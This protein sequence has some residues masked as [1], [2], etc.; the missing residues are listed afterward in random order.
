MCKNRILFYSHDA[1]G[2]GN[3]RR[4]L[5]M[6][7]RLTQTIPNLSILILTGSPVI[8]ALRIPEKV[9]YIK[10][11]CITRNKRE[12]FV[13]KYWDM[14]LKEMMNFRS[15][16]ILSSI[17]SFQ[18][19]IMIVDK[20]PLGI[21]R[22]LFDAL[23]FL[24]NFLP[25]TRI[26]LG[27]RDIL[28]EPATTIPIWQNNGYFDIIRDYYDAIWIY[29]DKRIFNPVIEYKMPEEVAQKAIFTGY[30]CRPKLSQTQS[31]IRTELGM[32]GE[33]FTLV[34]VGGGGDGFPILKT[35]VE[36]VRDHLE[37]SHSKTLLITGPE[38]P[39]MQQKML[40]NTCQASSNTTFFEFSDEIESFIT[41]A[42]VVVAMGGYNTTCEILSFRKRAVIIPRIH[43]V[44]EQYLRAKRLAQLRLIN[45]IHPQK[46]SKKKLF[47]TIEKTAIQTDLL[48][49]IDQKIDLKGLDRIERLTRE[50]LQC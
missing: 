49:N 12:T 1:Y 26:I 5:A 27:L 40:I 7:E 6:C 14:N 41:A 13:S 38:M 46:L 16:L 10:L 4:T 31:T 19:N 22:E 42:D 2:M 32:N 34:M 33:F 8:H 29:G 45:M 11:P 15:E 23:K 48:Q 9:D 50:I 21:K 28:D 37:R 44:K 17:K 47:E 20:K 24:K 30:L 43:P 25:N 18:P 35:Y 3:I 36:G 39:K